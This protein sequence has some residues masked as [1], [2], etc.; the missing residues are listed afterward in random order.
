M[1]AI[2]VGL[3]V[4]DIA[5]DPPI[6]HLIKDAHA[7]LTAES[8]SRQQLE[9]YKPRFGAHLACCE[10]TGMPGS[11][12]HTACNSAFASSVTARSDSFEAPRSPR[13]C[14]PSSC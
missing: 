14:R 1:Q 2:E 7:R 5:A 3:A 11:D 8:S 13:S 12:A 6:Y 4:I 10:H 9:H